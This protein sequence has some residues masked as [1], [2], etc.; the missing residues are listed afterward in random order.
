MENKAHALAA[1]AFVLVVSALLVAL[2]MWLTR[3]VA[4]RTVFEISTR[5]PVTGLQAQA[6]V[7]FRGIPV[8]KVLSIGFDPK[9]PGNVLVRISVDDATPITRS[10]FATLGFQGVTG[11]SFVQLDDS[12]ASSVA[13]E[14]GDDGAARIPLQPGLFSKLTDQGASAMAQFEET[15]RRLNALLAPEQQKAL[16]SAVRSLGQAAGSVGQLSQHLDEIVAAQLGPER[17]SLPQFVQEATVTLK[18]LQATSAEASRTAQQGSKAAGELAGVAQRLSQAGGTLDK[19][20]AGVG[21]L[22]TAGKALNASTLPRVTKAADDVALAARKV[23]RMAGALAENPQSLL[24]G[25][26]AAAP[27]PGE[28]GFSAPQAKP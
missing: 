3:D 14:G 6:A 9:V 15:T 10:T 11:L 24:Y 7:R 25:A 1:G 12:G 27:G 17:V 26:G 20:D 2:A 19:L 22:A 13:L 21:A 5:E 28:P 4:L 16:M 8:G 23:D 18:A